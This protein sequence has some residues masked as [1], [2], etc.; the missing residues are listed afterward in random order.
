MIVCVARTIVR[1]FGQL[2]DVLIEL[3]RG[4]EL[5][6]AGHES[7]A[8]RKA[9]GDLWKARI[10]RAEVADALIRDTELVELRSEARVQL[11][12]GGVR[13]AVE[14]IEVIGELVGNVVPR[15]DVVEA[16]HVVVT[17]RQLA[18]PEVEVG[19]HEDLV[20]LGVADELIRMPG[21]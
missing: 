6:G 16:V 19:A 1:S 9:Y 18:V 8:V 13:L 11:A 20:V 2:E 7:A 17:N 4:G 14:A 15:A 12:D 3:V 5:L 21:L 10:G